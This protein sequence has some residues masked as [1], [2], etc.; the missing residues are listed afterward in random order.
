MVP[1]QSTDHTQFVIP[2]KEAVIQ[3]Q[4]F[5]RWNPAILASR[6]TRMMCARVAKCRRPD[7]QGI[8]AACGRGERR[9]HTISCSFPA[10]SLL[11]YPAGKI[12][13]LLTASGKS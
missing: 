5:R 4:P 6:L 2:A 12:L 11:A 10:G 1:V 7:E 8:G 3:S 9:S 13:S